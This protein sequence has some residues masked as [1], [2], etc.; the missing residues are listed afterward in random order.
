MVRDI[1]PRPC[2]DV[3]R[4][5]S[6]RAPLA[7]GRPRPARV[8]VL[9]LFPTS[10]SDLRTLADWARHAGVS[11]AVLKTTCRLADVSPRRSLVLG[12][13]TRALIDQQRCSLRLEDLLDVHD[14]R[15]ITSWLALAGTPKLDGGVDTSF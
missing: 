2:L 14:P 10:G 9:L 6:E 7:D 4:A 1:S 3:E 5:L 15:T 12:R 8:P 11:V 13:L